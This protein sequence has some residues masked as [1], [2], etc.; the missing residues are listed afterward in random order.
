M[1]LQKFCMFHKTKKSYPESIGPR[2]IFLGPCEFLRKIG[3]SENV[4]TI[5][6]FNTIFPKSSSLGG[7][8]FSLASGPAMLLSASF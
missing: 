4:R 8:H 7:K 5:V 3:P 1:D 2:I 6:M